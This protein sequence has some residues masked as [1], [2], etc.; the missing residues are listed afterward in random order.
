MLEEAIK[1]LPTPVAA[2]G[3]EKGGGG[4]WSPTSAPL[5]QTLKDEVKLLPTPVANDDNKSPEAH[6]AMKRRLSERDGSERTQITSLLVLSKA[7]FKQPAEWQSS[8]ASTSPPSS[9]GS[10]STDLRLSP[11]FVEWMMGLPE[12]W[13]S[14]DCLLSAMEFKS[15]LDASPASTSSSSN[16]GG[17]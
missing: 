16:E 11:W 9:D 1:M 2:D 7:G 4:R 3:R 14:P 6:M 13:S 15:R 5:E 10:E 17:C 12:G 8:G